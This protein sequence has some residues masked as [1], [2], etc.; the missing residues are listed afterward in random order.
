[1]QTRRGTLQHPVNFLTVFSHP[2]VVRV[3]H[4]LIIHK[5]AMP[6]VVARPGAV[7]E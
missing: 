6:R 4:L 1:M 3:L 2:V 5:R 7:V